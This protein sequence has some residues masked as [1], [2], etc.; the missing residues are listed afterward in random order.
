MDQPINFIEFFNQHK[1][2]DAYLKDFKAHA[3]RMFTDKYYAIWLDKH[4]PNGG[5]VTVDF[6]Q[7]KSLA[8][9]WVRMGFSANEIVHRVTMGG[10][11]KRWT[12]PDEHQIL[13]TEYW[14]NLI[15]NQSNLDQY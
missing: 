11:Y 3:F 2:H 5:D 10:Q 8:L 14:N 9:D 1:L 6:R 4:F 7:L 13:T 12:L 15:L